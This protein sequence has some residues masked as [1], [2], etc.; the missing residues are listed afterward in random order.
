[1]RIEYPHSY[2]KEKV[3]EIFNSYFDTLTKR[4]LQEEEIDSAE[5][6]WNPTQDVM[7]ITAHIKG[8]KVTGQASLEKNRV[9][10]ESK[11]PIILLPFTP[12]IKQKIIKKLEDLL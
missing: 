1:M 10:I 4:K 11:L 9:V 12:I 7:K 6:S 2:S 5:K 3:Y 8:K